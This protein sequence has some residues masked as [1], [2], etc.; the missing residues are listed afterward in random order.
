MISWQHFKVYYDISTSQSIIIRALKISLIV[1]TA[2]NLINQSHA[3]VSFNFMDLNI[4][5]IFLTYSVPYL[6]TTYTATALKL[7]FQIG[8]KAS[9][10]ADLV[11]RKCKAQIHVKEN[12]LIPEDSTCGIKTKWRLK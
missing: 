5:K 2:L 1:G 10:E 3:I 6:V 4:I 11:C 9:V 12:E 8:T 7:E